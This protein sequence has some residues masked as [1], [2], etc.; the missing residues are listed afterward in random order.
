MNGG[1]ADVPSAANFACD[2]AAAAVFD[3]FI[4]CGPVAA[5]RM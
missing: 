5:E 2:E 4:N 3:A 1:R